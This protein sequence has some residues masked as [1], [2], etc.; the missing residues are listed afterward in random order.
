MTGPHSATVF[1]GGNDIGQVEV[2]ATDSGGDSVS[3]PDWVRIADS[4]F[5]RVGDDFVA[6]SADGRQAI[7]TDYFV[8]VP[9][10][11]LIGD[12]GAILNAAVVARLAPL[13]PGQLAQAD[14]SR[15]E[16][17]GEVDNIAGTVI[18]TRADGTRVALQPGDPVYQGDMLETGPDGAVG[19]IFADETSFAMAQS[20]RMIL[21]EMIYDPATA[22]GVFNLSIFQGVFSFVSGE[23]AR[24]NPDAMMVH[25][26][27]IAESW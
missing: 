10:P 25:T 22:E 13:A 16:P 24:A 5:S 17:I 14:L 18:A 1:G 23:V 21:D 9:A 27:A 15:A 26:R 4:S 7:V 11:D 2:I 6:T 12:D 19:I 3:L 20:G 8:A